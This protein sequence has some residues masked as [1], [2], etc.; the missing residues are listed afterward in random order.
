MK[1]WMKKNVFNVM[2]VV[3]I[4]TL[5]GLA[6]RWELEGEIEHE[7]RTTGRVVEAYADD[8]IREVEYVPSVQEMIINY[9]KDLGVD[10]N[11][12]LAIAKLE[13]GYFSSDGFMYSNN[14]G[15]MKMNGKLMQ[16]E[17]IEDGIVAFVKNI[18]DNYVAIGMSTP[19]EM[20]SK[21]CPDNPSGWADAVEVLME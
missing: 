9:S 17:S 2:L 5:F 13:T 3:S 11:L 8:E 16:F 6:G 7:L 10:S 18:A 20:A 1:R 21:Y 4:L 19:H 15:G 14:V 12:S